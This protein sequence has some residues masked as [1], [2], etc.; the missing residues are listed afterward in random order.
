M[1]KK[2]WILAALGM[3]TF[4]SSLIVTSTSDAQTNGMERRGERRDD[5]GDGRDAKQAC[6]EGD[7]KS[8]PECREEK[9]DEKHDKGGDADA[10]QQPAEPKP[11]GT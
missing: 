5:R 11:E 6:K 4:G 10:A 3:L 2:L 9:R 8:R 7:E 1:N